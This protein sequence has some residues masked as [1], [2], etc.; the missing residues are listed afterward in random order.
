MSNAIAVRTCLNR[1]KKQNQH[2]ANHPVV[3]STEEIGMAVSRSGR[4]SNG[5]KTQAKEDN[6]FRIRV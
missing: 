2:S 5:Y 1:L 3:L 4:A 6:G